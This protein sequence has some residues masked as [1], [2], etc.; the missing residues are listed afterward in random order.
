ME[1]ENMES[2][3]QSD[4]HYLN[5]RRVTTKSIPKHQEVEEEDQERHYKAV[6]REI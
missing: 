1:G 6:D 4:K 3:I 2:S 5:N